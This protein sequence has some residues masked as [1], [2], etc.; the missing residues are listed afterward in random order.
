[1]DLRVASILPGSL[2]GRTLGHYQVVEQV[3]AGGMG[4]VY[5][6]HDMR[7]DRDVALKLLPARVAGDAVADR[8]FRKEAIALSKLNHPNVATIHDFDT[9]DGINFVVM[10]FIR[11]A[12]LAARLQSGP[13]P[14]KAVAMI[15]MQIAAALDEAH[16]QGIVHRDLKPKNIMFT[17]K[18]QVKVLDFGV[19]KIVRAAREPDASTAS[20]DMTQNAAVG[21]LPY[22]APEQVRGG[23]VDARADI[24]AAGAVL[25]EMAT[26]VVPFTAT[27]AL[28]LI[29]AITTSA[30]PAPTQLNPQVSPSL[31]RIILK[32]LDKDPER[33]YQSARE[34]L[35]DLRRLDVV[36]TTS[37]LAA[38]PRRRRMREP[39][40]WVVATGLVV[41]WSWIGWHVWQSP[42]PALQRPEILIGEFENR[43]NDAVFDRTLQELVRASLEQSRYL[44]VL[45]ASRVR[46]A[47]ERMQREPNTPIDEA[48]GRELCERQGL[49][50][51]VLGSI[52]RLGGGYVL[53]ARALS[54]TG[55]RLASAQENVSTADGVY[56]GLDAVV[57]KLRTDLGESLRSVQETSAPLA[58]V[59]SPSID[60]VRNFTI[61]KGHLYGGRLEDA[62]GSFTNAVTLDPGFATAHAYLGVAYAHVNDPV[63]HVEHLSR[64]VSLSRGTEVERL[65]IRGD[66]NFAIGNYQEAISHHK[67][68][69]ELLPR[70]PAPHLNLGLDYAGRFDF[71]A[72]L[73]ATNTAVG[74]VSGVY[75]KVNLA[76]IH[77]LRGDTQRA[78]DLARE[79]RRQLP[80]DVQAGMVLGQALAMLGQLPDATRVYRDLIPTG[81]DVEGHLGLASLA[82][83]AERHREART[84]FEAGLLAADKQ[85]NRYA[86]AQGRLAL[87]DLALKEGRAAD[88]ARALARIG[89][90][91]ADPLLVFRAGRANARG[92]QPAS[93]QKELRELETLLGARGTPQLRSFCAMLDAELALGRDPETA[94]KAAEAAVA[95]ENSTLARETLARSY[96]AAGRATDAAREFEAV[97]A[98]RNERAA[99]YDAPAFHEVVG[100]YYELGVLYQQSGQADQA[101]AHLETFVK[102]WSD[103][104][105]PKP[106]RYADA[107]KRLQS[108]R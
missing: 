24:W 20:G 8:R 101:R 106:G 22:M 2:A 23:L 12:T 42:G 98:R 30:P 34:L 19:A 58:Q 95:Y 80:H 76:M 39:I 41:F 83:A 13:L 96:A 97:L 1:M 43:A 7:L 99:T 94:V 37:A 9:Q 29:Y 93:A 56:D 90:H 66:Y 60:A 88:I 103:P 6:A 11:G 65:K 26:S 64:A 69:A 27:D 46:D 71:D 82:L 84:H 45:S 92:R 17:P 53:M 86:A 79:V 55:E 104:D 47:L 28:G 33:R 85:Q 72:A 108:Q 67:A 91:D 81:G 102:Y 38:S 89:P 3:G 100:L 59:S 62:I 70:D 10:E 48:I 4:V 40:R 78:V 87:A 35:V 31:E 68:L 77:F 61:G 14:E 49:R 57:R 107:L 52:S 16:E 50:A 5:R 15:G 51:V 63:R 44:T 36:T 21:T 25:Y 18:D 32:A 105:L 74:L 54:P 73:A 75:P